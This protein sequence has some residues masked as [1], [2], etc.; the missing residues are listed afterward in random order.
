MNAASSLTMG[1]TAPQTFKRAQAAS[2]GLWVFM[3]VVSALFGLFAT[4]ALVRHR[5]LVRCAGGVEIN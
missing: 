2:T 1:A 4:A 3:A 5:S